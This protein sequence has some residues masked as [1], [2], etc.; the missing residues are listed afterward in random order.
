MKIRFEDRLIIVLISLLICT[1]S[2]GKETSIITIHVEKAGSLSSY[3]AD[4]KKYQISSLKLIGDLNGTDI[5]YIREMSNKNLGSLIY[6]DL[7]EANIVKGGISYNENMYTSDYKIGR[8]MFQKT[9]LQTIQLPQNI[10]VIEYY[11]FGDC[12]DL[13]SISIP[14]SVIEIGAAAFSWCTFT[15]IHIPKKVSTIS[16]NAFSGC[17]NLEII[18]VDNGN[19]FF[20]D[21]DGILYNKD[22]T[23]VLIC[24]K[25]KKGKISIP[26]S[27][28]TIGDRAFDQCDKLTN[29]ILPNNLKNIKEGAF[30]ACIGLTS[31][32]IPSNVETIEN[33]AFGYCY[34][35]ESVYCFWKNPIKINN[36]CFDHSSKQIL[37]VPNGCYDVYWLA[38]GWGEFKTIIE[39]NYEPTANETILLKNELS[40]KN[41]TN[42]IL[43]DTNKM[44]NVYI[45]N[46][47]GKLLYNKKVVGNRQITL[48][49]G[50]YIV[51]ADNKTHKIV[52][53]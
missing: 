46:I 29:I 23:E 8:Y 35:L 10:T 26:N 51:S 50:I 5:R 9:R 40:I 30:Y 16:N 32:S 36:T 1:N 25:G 7:S 18:H 13:V 27:V 34:N 21:I 31:M 20:S 17:E 24:P 45:Y 37:Y 4:S 44:V 41:I 11:A 22:Q 33:Y 53:K 6:L 19:P 39:I 28:T 47:N 14:E 52:I 49:N 38:K 3:I 42:G 48:P 15:S 12:S 43:I 2:F